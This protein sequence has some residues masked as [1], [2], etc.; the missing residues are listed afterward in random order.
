MLNASAHSAEDANILTKRSIHAIL[1][2]QRIPGLQITVVKNGKI[3]LSESY[4][5]ANV[6]NSV[7][8]FRTIRFPFNSAS[9]AF[10]VSTQMPKSWA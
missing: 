10:A 2:E 8:A 4:G 9:R 3:A 5:M 1:K 6:E 7:A